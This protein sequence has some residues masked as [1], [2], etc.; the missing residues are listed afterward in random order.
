MYLFLVLLVHIHRSQQ[1]PSGRLPSASRKQDTSLIPA[2]T[3]FQ[4]QHSARCTAYDKVWQGLWT[5]T[6]PSGQRG[7]RSGRGGPLERSNGRPRR[8]LAKHPIGTRQAGWRAGASLCSAPRPSG[9]LQMHQDSSWNC[10]HAIDPAILSAHSSPLCCCTRPQCAEPL[11][12]AVTACLCQRTEAP[13]RP[14]LTQ[15]AKKVVCL[16]LHPRGSTLAARAKRYRAGSATNKFLAFASQP[17]PSA[18]QQPSSARHCPG[19]ISCDAF[20]GSVFAVHLRVRPS[21]IYSY[22]PLLLL[23]S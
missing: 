9:R 6:V 3:A 23:C 14:F 4:A 2:S 21:D 11:R 5:D 8:A 1:L 19:R 16:P 18:N 10:K 12:A 7:E 20:P 22:R 15:A 13:R 17:S